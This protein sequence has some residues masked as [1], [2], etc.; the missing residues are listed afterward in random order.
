MDL[1]LKYFPD[2]TVLQKEQFSALLP[3]YSEWNSK[4]NVISR[5]DMELFYTHH[6]LHSLTLTKVLPVKTG[7]RILDLGTGGGF[8]G[9][10]LAIF[11][12]EVSFVLVDSI[13]KKINV[14]HSIADS[15]GLSNI[16]TVHSRTEHI[17]ERFN[18]VVSRAVAPLPDLIKWTCNLFEKKNNSPVPNG[19]FCLKGGDLKQELAPYAKRATQIDITDFFNEPYFNEKKIIYLPCI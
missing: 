13:G 14:A 4:I 8:P 19:I 2:L 5:K 16:K 6:V 10:P 3:L 9:I 1:I 18:F 12:P 7:T 11:F 17:K 15:I